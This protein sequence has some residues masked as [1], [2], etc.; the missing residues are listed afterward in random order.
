MLVKGS[1][2]VTRSVLVTGS[3]L[4]RHEAEPTLVVESVEAPER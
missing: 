4:D 2:T 3:V 1:M